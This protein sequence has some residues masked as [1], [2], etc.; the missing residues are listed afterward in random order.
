MFFAN[1]F[2]YAQ[3]KRLCEATYYKTRQRLLA[4][5]ATLEPLFARHGI[6]LDV[7]RLRDSERSIHAALNDPRPLWIESPAVR[8]AARDLTYALDL[9]E[10]WLLG[11]RRPQRSLRPALA[12]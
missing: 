7:E 9:L 11:A 1:I 3:R 10:R 5:R 6:G 4:E 8:T 12:R 2:S